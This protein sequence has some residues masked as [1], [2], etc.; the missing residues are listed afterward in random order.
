[1]WK[2]GLALDDFA[3][4][5][6]T[7]MHAESKR[8]NPNKVLSAAPIKWLD[9]PAMSTSFTWFDGPF[10]QSSSAQRR[11][12]ARSQTDCRFAFAVKA[13][14]FQA[15]LPSS[16][17][18]ATHAECFKAMRVDKNQVLLCTILLQFLPLRIGTREDCCA[19]DQVRAHQARAV[20]HAPP[21]HRRMR[22]G[23]AHAS[24]F[25][26]DSR[27]H[28]CIQAEVAQITRVW[29]GAVGRGIED[30]QHY[31]VQPAWMAELCN[32]DWRP[33]RCRS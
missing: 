8:P 22:N 23:F 29:R 6:K 2:T 5:M 1:M 20:L 15:D 25:R 18:T 30:P 19:A 3:D 26:S 31:A 27:S 24:R 21:V 33:G 12:V 10:R 14:H 32:P 16:C 7:A 17:P 9:V 13:R 4:W 11:A 28:F